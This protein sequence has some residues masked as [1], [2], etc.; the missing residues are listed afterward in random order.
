[1]AET[2]ELYEFGREPGF[3]CSVYSPDSSHILHIVWFQY[4]IIVQISKFQ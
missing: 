3:S 1:M 4:N 2:D